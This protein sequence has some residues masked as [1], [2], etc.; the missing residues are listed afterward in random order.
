MDDIQ[1]GVLCDDIKAS[2]LMAAVFLCD[3]MPVSEGLCVAQ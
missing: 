2:L 3:T 1:T